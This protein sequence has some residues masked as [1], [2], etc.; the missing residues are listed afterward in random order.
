MNSK[1]VF[2]LK[3]NPSASTSITLIYL[4]SGWWEW[5]LIFEDKLG[6]EACYD[7]P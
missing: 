2:F 6:Y 5:R 1:I 4:Y 3:Y 7:N